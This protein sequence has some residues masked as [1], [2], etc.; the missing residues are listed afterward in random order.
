LRAVYTLTIF[1]CSSLLFLVEPMVAKMIL[2]TFG[3]SPS[4]WNACVLFFQT[5]LLLGYLYA[6][7]T[8]KWMGVKAQSLMHLAMM[9]LPAFVLPIAMPQWNPGG[10]ANPTFLLLGLLVAGAGLPFFVLSSG[11]PLLQKWFSATS[12]KDAKDP[13]FLY[14]ASNLGSFAALIAYPTLFEPAFQLSRQSLIWTYGY[15]VLAALVA[16]ATVYLWR[17]PSLAPIAKDGPR[18]EGTAL[19]WTDR[20]RWIA[21]S[22]VPSSLMLGVT[23][24]LTTNLAPIP[25]LWIIP[26]SLYL[27]TFV[28][29][30]RDKPL[31]KAEHLSRALPLIVTPMA[32]VMLLEATQPMTVLGTMHLAMFA[33]AALMCHTI[34]YRSRPSAKHVTEFYVWVSVGGVVGG[35]FNSI[36]A[37]IVFKTLAEYPIAIVA[38]CLLRP[39]GDQ[40]GRRAWD[41][42]YP[43]L[44]AAIT[45]G[46]VAFVRSPLYAQLAQGL[47]VPPISPMRTAIVFGLPAILSFF[48]ADRPMRFGL[49]L[50]AFLFVATVTR[51]SSGEQMAM[52]DRSF[53]GVHRVQ[54]GDAEINGQVYRNATHTYSHGNTIHGI[55]KFVDGLRYTPLTYYYPTGPI[56]EVFRL[57]DKGKRFNNVGLIGLGTGSLATY[58]RPGQKMVF[59]EIDPIVVSIARDSGYFTFVTDSKA[60]VSYVVGDARLMLADAKDHS[61][62]LMV[63]DAFSSDAIP[64]HLVTREAFELYLKKLK[65]GGLIAFHISNRYLNLNPIIANIADSL[66]LKSLAFDDSYVNAK[67][68]EEG[69]TQ[70][71]WMLIAREESDF[72]GIETK[73][74]WSLVERNPDYPVWT[75][76]YS[77]ILRVFEVKA[78]YDR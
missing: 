20:L 12:D 43:A 36:L 11:S 51:I 42:A 13:Y 73:G 67:E 5:T 1:V 38:A 57:L 28:A 21:L 77:N 46:L 3:G 30:F 44:I 61:Y 27:L 70:S 56:G 41:Y 24:Y 52:L 2:P 34:L 23:T 68:E 64:V 32:M 40:G 58:G 19:K 49:S 16:V 76:D 71:R 74:G 15:F 62:D 63:L 17:N 8:T 9:A 10:R 39:K 47:G 66:G 25:L 22:A 50:A 72:D 33:V 45:L 54:V 35:L 6:H 29:A 7:L 14:R 78:D 75:D 37:P 4:V 55:Q 53:F 48:V 60:E 65:P 18:D 26:L 31:V 69:K 59:Y